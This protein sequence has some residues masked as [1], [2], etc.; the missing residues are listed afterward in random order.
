MESW[1][2]STMSASGGNDNY[3]ADFDTA[4]PLMW[5]VE[6][7]LRGQAF[8]PLLAKH[9]NLRGNFSHPH[10]DSRRAA[11]MEAGVPTSG[12]SSQEKHYT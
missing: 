3:R 11:I 1:R 8:C 9:R 4:S 5:R 12:G 6:Q 10:S 7:L 2:C